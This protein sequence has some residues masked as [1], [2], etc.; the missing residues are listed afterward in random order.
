MVEADELCG[1]D[2]AGKET[3][4]EGSEGFPG[5]CNKIDVSVRSFL[6]LSLEYGRKLEYV[7]GW[8]LKWLNSR[9]EMERR[10]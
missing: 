2:Y 9:R 5:A 4:W 1:K 3:E 7:V 8:N 10:G 6:R